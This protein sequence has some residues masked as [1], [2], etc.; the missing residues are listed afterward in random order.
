VRFANSAHFSAC[1]RK[2]FTE[3]F[4]GLFEFPAI[5]LH[6]FLFCVATK[7]AWSLQQDFDPQGGGLAAREAPP[8]HVHA[9]VTKPSDSRHFLR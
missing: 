1:R 6:H 5:A 3:P 9:I 7:I 8:F 4:F 2:N